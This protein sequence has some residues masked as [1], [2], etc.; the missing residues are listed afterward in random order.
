[1]FTPFIKLN[2]IK[3]EIRIP[4]IIEIKLA[5][6]HVLTGE[7]NISNCPWGTKR[8]PWSGES[9]ELVTG[10]KFMLIYMYW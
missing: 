6:L 10:L 9:G 8:L 3:L 1:M 5:A 4:F 2:I 7:N